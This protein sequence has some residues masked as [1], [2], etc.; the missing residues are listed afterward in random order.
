MRRRFQFPWNAQKVCSQL[1]KSALQGH[2]SCIY[3][4][5]R[6]LCMCDKVEQ[7][8]RAKPIENNLC[9]CGLC[10]PYTDEELEDARWLNKTFQDAENQQD[11]CY[12]RQFDNYF[13]LMM[14]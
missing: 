2:C 5:R 11:I 14:D 7:C 8:F 6:V 9:N 12:C 4:D 13:E 3:D 1:Q 10:S